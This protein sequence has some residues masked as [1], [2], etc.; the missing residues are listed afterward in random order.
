[1]NKKTR[2]LALIDFSEYSETVVK[3]VSQ[4]A[5]QT[6]ADVLFVHH[7]PGIVPIV[8]DMGTRDEIIESERLDAVR[9][10]KDLCDGLI[11][12]NVDFHVSD[13]DILDI[14]KDL[15]DDTHTDWVFTGLKGTGFLKKIFIGSTTIKIIE[16]TD[17]LTLTFPIR[18][19][20]FMPEKLVVATHHKYPMN[21][22]QFDYVLENLSGVVREIDFFSLADDDDDE[23][24]CKEHLKKL[25]EQYSKYTTDIHVFKDKDKADLLKFYMRDKENTYLVLQQGSRKLSDN[26]FRKFMVNEFIYNESVPLI[27]MSE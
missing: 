25:S 16:N 15:K 10:L 5:K 18:K 19:E 13:K 1:M 24:L 11:S 2:I 20:V 6:S 21:K 17:F 9:K 8:P 26:I 4:F 22:I 12:G 27:V 23:V 3:I 14:L 7:L